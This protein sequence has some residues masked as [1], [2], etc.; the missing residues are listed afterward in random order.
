MAIGQV[1]EYPVGSLVRV[2]ERDWVVLPSDDANIIC[3]RPLSGSESTNTSACLRAGKA[4]GEL[5]RYG[6]S[7]D[8][9][10]AFA[11]HPAA[12]VF[13]WHQ[14][15]AQVGGGTAPA[16]GVALVYQAGVRSGHSAPFHVLN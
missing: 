12:R 7:V 4:E 10:R 2:R 1:G 8:C 16:S 9:S 15:P 3:L 6:A 11:A 13:V 5:Q 14:Q